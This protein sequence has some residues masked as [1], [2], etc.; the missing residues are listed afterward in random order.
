MSPPLF[1]TKKVYQAVDVHQFNQLKIDF[2]SNRA[3]TYTQMSIRERWQ[4]LMDSFEQTT[5]DD[6]SQPLNA[7]KLE[8]LTISPNENV[9]TIEKCLPYFEC[10]YFLYNNTHP[11]FSLSPKRKKELLYLLKQAIAIVGICEPG[12]LN[13]FENIVHEFRHDLNWIVS[14][15][16]KQR[17]ATLLQLQDQYNEHYRIDNEFAIFTYEIM[18]DVAASYQLGLT[19]KEQRIKNI[20]LSDTASERIKAYFT[21]HYQPLFSQ[22]EKSITNTLLQGLIEECQEWLKN[23][24]PISLEELVKKPQY[25]LQLCP[26]D[27][28]LPTTTE[29]NRLYLFK[30]DNQLFIRDATNPENLIDIPLDKTS[31]DRAIWEKLLTK[32]NPLAPEPFKIHNKGEDYFVSVRLPHHTYKLVLNRAVHAMIETLPFAAV[33][34][35]L[36]YTNN[37]WRITAFDSEHIAHHDVLKTNEIDVFQV[38]SSH[39]QRLEHA[40]S[41]DELQKN[42]LA[43]EQLLQELQPTTAQLTHLEEKQLFSVL[44]PLGYFPLHFETQFLNWLQKKYF[45]LDTIETESPMTATQLT[46]FET[47]ETFANDLRQMIEHQ[48]I[49]DQFLVDFSTFCH[50]VENEPE[51]LRL[52]QPI[53]RRALRATLKA[54]QTSSV[55]LIAL[56]QSHTNVLQAYPELF[57]C[58]TCD[59]IEITSEA[60]NII[61]ALPL[62]QRFFWVN[63]CCQTLIAQWLLASTPRPENAL[64]SVNH[65]ASEAR[66]HTSENQSHLEAIKIKL[67]RLLNTYPISVQA[68]TPQVFQNHALV[69]LLVEKNSLSFQQL[70]SELR[71]IE[72]IFNYALQQ[73]PC[74]FFY[75]SE[76]LQGQPVYFQQAKKQW[77]VLLQRPIVA[78]DIHTLATFLRGVHEELIQQIR[79]LDAQN[80]LTDR[81]PTPEHIPFVISLSEHNNLSQHLAIHYFLT[82]PIVTEWAFLKFSALITPKTLLDIKK[83]REKNKHFSA[84]PYLPSP[85]FE[86][87]TVDSSTN[88]FTEFYKTLAYFG[89]IQ[90]WDHF[91]YLAAKQQ[92]TELLQ[93]TLNHQELQVITAFVNSSTWPSSYIAY[94]QKCTQLEF[95]S[96]YQLLQLILYQFILLCLLLSCFVILSDIWL[97]FLCEIIPFSPVFIMM[98]LLSCIFP[99]VLCLDTAKVL[100]HHPWMSFIA[101]LLAFPFRLMSSYLA[102]MDKI[103]Q[104]EHFFVK[105]F[106]ESLDSFWHIATRCF[107]NDKSSEMD[108]LKTRCEHCLFKLHGLES[109]FAKEQVKLLE[110][111]WNKILYDTLPTN[112]IEASHLHR[113]YT[114]FYQGQHHVSFI[115]VLTQKPSIDD[116]FRL[117]KSAKSEQFFGLWSTDRDLTWLKELGLLPETTNDATNES[118][119]SMPMSA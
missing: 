17:H 33:N 112:D 7:F 67:I 37:Q 52:R 105:Y 18:R 114:L 62:S 23:S 118:I 86:F 47:H 42:H 22:Y 78:D 45:P 74:A 64:G 53:S 55:S 11:D 88:Y 20:Y 104:Y 102:E 75:A 119:E 58:I 5:P 27:T 60:F 30:Q 63:F 83:I 84:L 19:E 108:S 72:Q 29:E 87:E 110:I 97:F 109:T 48:L 34:F 41:N 43:I 32:L 65:S 85:S 28:P 25:T 79:D 101:N 69:A 106:G 96:L 36:L 31:F 10:Y 93:Q 103:G 115:D 82:E 66:H 4:W 94:Y 70:P 16:S 49:Q 99:M 117:E 113:K 35:S 13:R 1:S 76:R 73:D 95:K 38:T 15:L 39:H 61:H 91:G 90:T 51:K 100:D 89:I 92:A 40:M 56:I 68:I 12:H 2:I 111:L 116:T 54:L 77:A 26:T 50:L 9:V 3:P 44:A 57:Q 80:L 107:S 71:D 6:F 8:R 81:L 46:H 14:F 59:N 21:A 24:G 98:T